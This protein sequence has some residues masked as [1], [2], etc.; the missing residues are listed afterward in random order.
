MLFDWGKISS[1][2][3]STTWRLPSEEFS[4]WISIHFVWHLVLLDLKT[5]SSDLQGSTMQSR[6]ALVRKFK[7]NESE[8]SK[9]AIKIKMMLFRTIIPELIIKNI[10]LQY[11][12][13][14]KSYKWCI[15]LMWKHLFYVSNSA[16]PVITSLTP[17][18][19]AFS[20]QGKPLRVFPISL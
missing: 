13:F 8:Q 1:K 18:F 2:K 10:R 5:T 19:H 17:Q 6:C 3:V 16:P 11:I 4:E 9:K 7:L 15:N 20:A 14:S 12:I